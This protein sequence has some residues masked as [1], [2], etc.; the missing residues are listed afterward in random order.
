MQPDVA[1]GQVDA[2][3]DVGLGLIVEEDA[4]EVPANRVVAECLRRSQTGDVDSLDVSKGVDGHVLR[5]SGLALIDS[6]SCRDAG[7]ADIGELQE[8]NAA[9]DAGAAVGIDTAA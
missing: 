5:R 4:V 6:R 1:S 7:D 9:G 2:I 8:V 3:L